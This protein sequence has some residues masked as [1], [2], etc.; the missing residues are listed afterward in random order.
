[1]NLKRGFFRVWVTTAVGWMVFVLLSGI[2]TNE[3]AW[4]TALAMICLPAAIAT[5][6]IGTAWA[7][8]TA[9]ARDMKRRRI[10]F[11][12]WGA[13]AAMWPLFLFLNNFGFRVN[14]SENLFETSIMLS[15]QIMVFAAVVAAIDWVVVGFQSRVGDD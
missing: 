15:G 1:M 5:F 9:A 3:D 4:L 6:V 11:I 14:N 10:L 8:D 7:F 2:T 12:I 13:A